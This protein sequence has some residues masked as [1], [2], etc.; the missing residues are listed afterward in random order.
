MGGKNNV[1]RMEHAEIKAHLIIHQYIVRYT[2]R[3]IVIT[4]GLRRAKAP[5]NISEYILK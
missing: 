3:S 4:I 5:R 1:A 2:E